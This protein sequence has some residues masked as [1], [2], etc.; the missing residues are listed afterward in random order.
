MT[1]DLSQLKALN[2]GGS[3]P[4]DPDPTKFQ[5]SVR[6]PTVAVMKIVGAAVPLS[7]DLWL[8]RR[9]DA[10]KRSKSQIIRLV[11]EREMRERAES[12]LVTKTG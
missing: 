11:L 2:I 8:Q 1:V 12:T 6:G 5:F 7:I 4:S 3:P 10:E 9:A